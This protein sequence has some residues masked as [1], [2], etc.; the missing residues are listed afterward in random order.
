VPQKLLQNDAKQRWKANHKK[1]LKYKNMNG[2]LSETREHEEG[3]SSN[4]WSLGA[5]VKLISGMY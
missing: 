4:R 5:T 3:I 2:L 1:K